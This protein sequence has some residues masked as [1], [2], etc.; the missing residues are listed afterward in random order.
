MDRVGR[1]GGLA[2]E[3]AAVAT[4]RP[5]HEPRRPAPGAPGTAPHR[6]GDSPM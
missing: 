2:P 4:S 1:R 6:S 3:Q 5:D